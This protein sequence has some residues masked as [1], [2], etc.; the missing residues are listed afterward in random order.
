[1]AVYPCRSRARSVAIGAVAL[2]AAVMFAHS[3]PA[4]A[5]TPCK[6]GRYGGESSGDVYAEQLDVAG[7]P[8]LT[9]HYAP[10]CL[11]A[12]SLTGILLDSM[13]R[14]G[15]LPSKVRIR[16]ARWDA[17]IW[18]VRSVHLV[19]E[20]AHPYESV[21]A[22]RGRGRITVILDD[23]SAAEEYPDVIW[24]SPIPVRAFNG[25]CDPT[26]PTTQAVPGGCTKIVNY[27]VVT[28]VP[29]RDE[30]HLVA[31]RITK[32]SDYLPPAWIMAL[33]YQASP[34]NV[35]PRDAIIR[36][37]GGEVHQSWQRCGACDPAQPAI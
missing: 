18:R 16:G 6:L 7:L 11:V 27:D 36:W 1:M 31:L 22:R 3:A 21:T 17:G 5:A 9:S 23:I 33:I 12:E 35:A 10:R 4:H 34:N 20:D 29:D 37:P 28:T 30:A 13:D 2:A 25:E 26:N 8:R 32:D 24:T 19:D 15:R 14:R